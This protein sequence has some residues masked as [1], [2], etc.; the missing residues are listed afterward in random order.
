MKEEKA[1]N[2]Y[3]KSED[4]PLYI[5][6]E[7]EGR[8]WV[9]KNTYN[10]YMRDRW[11]EWKQKERLSRCNVP[12]EKYGLKRCMKNCFECIYFRN[13]KLLSI[14][15]IYEEYELEIEDKSVSII[16]ELLEDELKEKLWQAR[17]ELEQ[18][19][20]KIILLFSEGYS[21]QQISTILI[22]PRTTINYRKKISLDFLRKKLKSYMNL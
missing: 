19:D 9:D 3:E 13:N 18:L 2:W 21:E 4:R 22:I 5:D 7:Y 15:E 1:I 17:D 6:L 8:I 11:K 10:N 12:D 16:D 14:E 20:Q